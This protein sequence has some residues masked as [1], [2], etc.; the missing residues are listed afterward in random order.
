MK[1]IWVFFLPLIFVACLIGVPVIC[2][3]IKVYWGQS[4]LRKIK[5]ANF[6]D[7]KP[8]DYDEVLSACFPELTIS[9]DE[10][11]KIWLPL[12]DGLCID[13]KYLRPEDRLDDARMIT[14]ADANY[15]IDVLE[16]VESQI[17]LNRVTF[18]GLESPWKFPATLR[19]AVYLCLGRDDL[20]ES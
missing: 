8:M 3:A 13:P 1:R 18:R 12:G 14:E 5:T 7:R 11:G 20:I 19:D 4:R 10:F 15:D 16:E 17:T 6:L 9:V 2:I